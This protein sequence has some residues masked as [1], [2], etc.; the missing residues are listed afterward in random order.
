FSEDV[1]KK[2]DNDSVLRKDYGFNHIDM[3]EIQFSFDNDKVNQL[4]NEIESKRVY[5]EL[6]KVNLNQSEEIKLRALA[7]K[8]DNLYSTAKKSGIKMNIKVLGY[9]DS[10]GSSELINERISRLRAEQV[11]NYLVEKSMD[12]EKISFKGMGKYKDA[13]VQSAD[14]SEQRVVMIKIEKQQNHD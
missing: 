11:Y 9:A 12:S 2:I 4:I 5:F 6:G 1:K 10:S 13:T 14:Q 8:I 7:E 3:S